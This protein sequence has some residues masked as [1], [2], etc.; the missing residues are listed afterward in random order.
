[1]ISRD[2][3]GWTIEESLN[4]VHRIIS[5]I[6]MLGTV[7]QVEF[8]TGHG[9][10]QNAVMDELKTQGLKPAIQLSNSGVVIVVI[11]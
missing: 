11:E 10:I 2:F 7:E 6:R 8:I 5:N 4:E 3:H 1:M 9:I